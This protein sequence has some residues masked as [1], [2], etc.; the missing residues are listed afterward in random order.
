ME[1]QYYFNGGQ[2]KIRQKGQFTDPV[3]K[4]V[5]EFES[6]MIIEAGKDRDGR[7]AHVAVGYSFVAKLMD[8]MEQED[9]QKWIEQVKP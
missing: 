8:L 6:A 5:R 7:V 2:I 1:K 9:F 4:Q 3:T